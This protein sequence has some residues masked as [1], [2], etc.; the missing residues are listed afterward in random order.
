M[1]NDILWSLWGRQSGSSL[2][3]PRGLSV[4]WYCSPYPKKYS[5]KPSVRR[6]GQSQA[7]GLAGGIMAH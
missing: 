5:A 7:N 3:E 4:G 2:V 1:L 6:K